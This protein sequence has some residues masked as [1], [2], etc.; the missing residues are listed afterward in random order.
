[1]DGNN[2]EQIAQLRKKTKDFADCMRT[3]YLS[4]N[5]AWYTI[6]TTILKTLEYPMTATTISETEWEGI[7]VPLLKAG[8]PRAGISSKF[9]RDILYGPTTIQG[10][11]VFHLWYHH[12]LKHLIVLL[13]SGT[14]ITLGFGA[15]SLTNNSL[16]SYLN[17]LRDFI[18]G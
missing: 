17:C 11:G 9:P 5:N 12:Q 16:S 8:L 3:G 6:N 4:K 2:T 1:M 15:K 18:P 10:F 13:P 14:I 7:M